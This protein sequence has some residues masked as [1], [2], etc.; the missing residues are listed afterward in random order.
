MMMCDVFS[1][2]SRLVPRDTTFLQASEV[3]EEFREPGILSGYRACPATVR[4]CAGSLVRASNETVNFWTHFIPGV[5]FL[6]QALAHMGCSEGPYVVYLF[7]VAVFMLTSSLAHGFWP[8]STRGLDLSFFLDYA[9][10][11]IYAFG[12]ACG[13]YAYYFAPG[14]HDTTLGRHYVG[15]AGMLSPICTLIACLS[16]YPGCWKMQ[17]ISRLAGFAVLYTWTNLPLIYNLT[18]TQRFDDLANEL[19]HVVLLTIAAGVYGSHWPERWFPGSFDIIGS[20][21]NLLHVFGTTAVY[22]QFCGLRKAKNRGFVPGNSADL[23][24]FSAQVTSMMASVLMTDM[25]I[26]VTCLLSKARNFRTK[27]KHEDF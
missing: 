15:I 16:R 23:Q 2:A 25:V 27:F 1:I 7:S 22:Y 6:L 4:S 3:P 5:F 21:H 12:S 10:M 26:I 13:N 8:V 24:I 17:K 20:S 18:V 19:S 9:A 14:F 11:N